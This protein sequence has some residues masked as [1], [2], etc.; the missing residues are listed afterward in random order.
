VV[1]NDNP[2]YNE[3]WKLVRDAERTISMFQPKTAEHK[4]DREDLTA[5]VSVARLYADGK[6]GKQGI[7]HELRES[8]KSLMALVRAI[9]G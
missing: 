6:M 8:I 5:K 9:M 3:D 2:Y 7:P 4:Q 1:W